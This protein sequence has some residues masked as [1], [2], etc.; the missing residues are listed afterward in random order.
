[1][2]QKPSRFQELDPAGRTD[3]QLRIAL[4]RGRKFAQLRL[5]RSAMAYTRP[6]FGH[7]SSAAPTALEIFP[8]LKQAP[9]FNSL[10][11]IEPPK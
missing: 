9:P 2:E 6:L 1:L 5:S 3:D 7:A 4:I 11:D 10:P 8:L